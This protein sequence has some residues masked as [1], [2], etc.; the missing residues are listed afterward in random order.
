MVP[1]ARC[2]PGESQKSENR[3]PRKARCTLHA[4]IRTRYSHSRTQDAARRNGHRLSI[5]RWCHAA[6]QR[7]KHAN[8]ALKGTLAAKPLAVRM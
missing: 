6:R 2:K 1:K 8:N 5:P 3:V 4:A 7:G